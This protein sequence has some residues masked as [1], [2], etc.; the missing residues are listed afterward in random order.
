MKK[1]LKDL[2]IYMHIHENA[3]R[4][5]FKIPLDIPSHLIEIDTETKTW[6]KISE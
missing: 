6:K 2:A 3:Y 1:T 4:R 5:A